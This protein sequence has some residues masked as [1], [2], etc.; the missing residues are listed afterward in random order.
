MCD[1]PCSDWGCLSCIVLPSLALFCSSFVCVSPCLLRGGGVW[2]CVVVCGGVSC[3]SLLSSV[4]CVCCH[5]IVDLTACLCGMVMS[6]WNGGDGLCVGW[7][8]GGVKGCGVVVCLLRLLSLPLSLP[9]PLC[10]GVRGSA[11][12][13]LRA[14]TLSPNTIVFP[15]FLLFAPPVSFRSSP[16]FFARLSSVGIA[17]GGSPCVRVFGWHDSDG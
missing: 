2:W 10:V 4:P 11:R 14:R 3:Y 6:T 8:G 12:A 13:A 1:A 5:I 17:V 7:N 9:L 16:F 15:L